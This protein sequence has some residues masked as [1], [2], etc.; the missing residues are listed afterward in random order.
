MVEDGMYV[1]RKD[2][3][4]MIVDGDCRIGPPEECLRFWRSIVQLDVDFQVRF[5]WMECEAS[6]HFR[7]IDAVDFT[8]VDGFAAVGMMLDGI[9]DRAKGVRAMVLGPIEFDA[10]GNPGAGQSNQGWFD[11]AVVVDEIVVIGFIECAVDAP[12]EFRHDFDVEVFVLKKHDVVGYWLFI[13]LNLVYNGIGVY[14]ARTALID[15]F[16]Q[17]HG[18]FVWFTNTIGWNFDLLFPDVYGGCGHWWC[19]LLM[20]EIMFILFLSHKALVGHAGA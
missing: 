19:S 4:C 13:V 14:F 1:G 2:R 12:T 10:A 17:K 20:C 9:F 5:P 6:R 3:L 7:A 11:D 18:V 8:D 16:L 15:A